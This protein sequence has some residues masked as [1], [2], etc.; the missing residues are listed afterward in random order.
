M[1]NYSLFFFPAVGLL[2]AAA[3]CG[4]G[5]DNLPPNP[6]PPPLPVETAEPVP[7]ST[8]SSAPVEP[9]LP[10][11]S[12][13]SS[14]PAPDP[15][16]PL[17]TV[18][19]TTPTQKQVVAADK[20]ADFAVK[21]DVKNWATAQGSQHVHLIL[22]G[23]PYKAIYD[24]KVPVKLSELTNG[25]PLTE[26]QHILVA[27]PSRPTHESVKSKDALAI[28]EFYVG[29]K[30]DALQD[31]KKPMLI[32]SRPKGEYKGEMGNHI[33]VDFQLA[34]AKLEEGKDTVKITVTG[35]GIDKELTAKSEKF[36]TPFF[37]D[38]VR[39]GE[40]S[41]KLE[42]VG[43][44]GKTLPGSWNTTTRTFKV[45]KNAPADPMPHPMGDVKSDATDAGAPKTDAGKAPA[46]KPADKPAKK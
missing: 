3:A 43:A 17:P 29:K 40:Y 6:P 38:E 34:N 1:R 22:D 5:N 37:I 46:A 16:A 20:A 14:A 33:L 24:A 44:D 13:Q 30:G 28:V 2:A 32:Y 4:G 45:D 26:G 21:L 8:A 7:S 42:L 11:V 19:I 25:E 31:I 23:K 27:F 41:V 35:P 18:K 10:P 15:T 39:N 12:I 9:Q 36:G